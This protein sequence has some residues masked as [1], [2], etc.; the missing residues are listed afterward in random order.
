MIIVNEFQVLKGPLSHKIKT[1]SVLSEMHQAIDKISSMSHLHP[2]IDR[3]EKPFFTLKSL[4]VL[5]I[6]FAF[7][8]AVS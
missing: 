6:T 3:Y 2:D 4:M 1:F 7:R 8:Y 5:S